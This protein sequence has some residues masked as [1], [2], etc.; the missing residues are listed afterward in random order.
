[1]STETPTPKTPP[2]GFQIS[3]W[4]IRNPIPVI[5][6]FIVM[7]IAGVIGFNSLR[8]NNWPDIDF[9]IVVV[10]VVRSGAAPTELQNQVTRI[11]EDSVSGLGGVRHIQSYVNEGASTTV[12]T[13]QLETDLEKA[14][15][16]VRNA[17]AGVRMNLPGDVQ[18]PIVSRVENAQGQALLSYTI[19]A[20]DMTPDQLSW[21]VDNDVAKKVLGV[22]GVSQLTRDGGVT[23]EIRIELDPAKLAAQGVSAGD[24]SRQL[25]AFNVNMPGGRF[26]AGTT[27]QTIRTIGGADS[28]TQ[29]AETRITLSNGS[30]VR[31]GDLGTVTDTW[32]EPRARAR[33]DGNEV[34]GF[35]I[36]RTR[37]T[38]EHHV[39]ERVRKVIDDLKKQNP[40]VEIEEV[41]SSVEEV[42][43]SFRASMEALVIGAILAV[44]VVYLFLRDWRATFVS[45]VAMP[46]S[47]LPTFFV[48]ALLN[49]SFN[50]V[51]L[52]ALS[53]TIG[54]LVDDAI[55]EIENIVRHIREGK[56]PYPAAI[57][58]A[59]EIG[60]AVV[61]TTA[62]L[63][64]VFAPTGFM[65]GIVGQFFES[66]AVATCVSVFFSLVVARTLTPLM[67]AYL[68]R[69][70]AEHDHDVPFWMPTYQAMLKWTLEGHLKWRWYILFHGVTVLLA[71]V[72]A[73]FTSKNLVI[74]GVG[75]AVFLVT[76]ILFF[77][78][79]NKYMKAR[80][81]ALEFGLIGSIGL[82][83][84]GVAMAMPQP[85]GGQAA[86]AASAAAAAQGNTAV[87]ILF[88]LLGLL[89]LLGGLIWMA[90]PKNFPPLLGWI[91][92]LAGT[93]LFIG[94]FFAGSPLVASMRLVVFGVLLLVGTFFIVVRMKTSLLSG[95]WAVI[96]GGIAFFIG[97]L[98]LSTLIPS[99][100]FPPEDSGMSVMNISLPPGSTLAE[101]DAIVKRVIGEL[102]ARDEVESTYATINM[103]SAT[104][105]A[106]L[107]SRHVEWFKTGEDGKFHIY[108]G[109]ERDLSQ[110]QFEQA[111]SRQLENYPGVRA[112]FGQAGGGGTGVA[113][114]LVGEDEKILMSTLAQLQREMQ[115]LPE[116]A[117]VRSEDNLTRPEI[118][119]TPKPDQAALMGVSTQDISSVARV[120]TV[121]DIDQILAKFNQGDRQVPI[122]VLLK[123]DAR[124]DVANLNNLMVPTRFGTSVPLSAVADISFGAGPIQI[125]RLDR[126]RTATIRADLN[127]VPTGVADGAV[128]KTPTMTKIKANQIPGVRTVVNPD[129][130]DF[131]EM[132]LNFGIAILTGIALM[133]VVLV[134]L[135]GSFSH[136]FTIILALPLCFGGAFV[137]LLLFQM[138]MSMPAFIGLIMLVGI[139]AK[140]SILLVEYAMVA[141]KDGMTRTEALFEAAK[142]RA[143]PIVMTTIAMGAGMIP[144]VVGEDAFRQPMAVTV[145]GGLIT[146]TLL[147]LLFVPATYTVIDQISHFLGKLI[148][149]AF[150]AQ[151]KD[152]PEPEPDPAPQPVEEWK[153]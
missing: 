110:P 59:D 124:L 28:V 96:I 122:R 100:N 133:Y 16:D 84:L 35:G 31:L 152:E 61:A 74:S 54:I 150:Q 89:V 34:V 92:A 126:T 88:S 19:R 143:R 81:A 30:T 52:L 8:I 107:T 153:Y 108:K 85:G 142:K 120:A 68:L 103:N 39:A 112:S 7:T 9:P 130:E 99:D 37:G 71:C 3:S 56:K 83:L 98:G 25:S 119:I 146:S 127:G 23:R 114:I 123:E 13:F 21:Y 94:A 22:K 129:T 79:H 116:L 131:A 46:M 38:S 4:S 32:T 63:I 65:P 6:F 58:A 78:F 72:I 69:A 12:I 113:Y 115:A 11:V 29:L 149:P 132:P 117:N 111:F 45:A 144:V 42:D 80:W 93:L 125:N 50:V 151:G 137:G 5:V 10:T 82:I 24:I 27:E 48:M 135:F 47:L 43:R 76:L 138:S 90:K 141:I 49:Q 97:S 134:L 104:I 118:V 139:A 40:N 51:T 106:N 77:L 73:G 102:H 55:V 87:V 109:P 53:L 86:A 140:N 91:V 1:M 101:T 105:V 62:T 26:N 67:G 148:S 41:T 33:F 95:R 136:P 60:L 20:A 2:T 121:G 44:L 14:T 17:V 128:A 64:A 18:D 145:I 15:N 57:E 36:Q 70:N 147:S 66:F 75:G